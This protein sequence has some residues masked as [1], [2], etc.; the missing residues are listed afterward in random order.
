M[1]MA[2]NKQLEP[3]RSTQRQRVSHFLCGKDWAKP[4]ANGYKATLEGGLRAHLCHWRE[5][6]REERMPPPLL[7]HQ[8]LAAAHRMFGTKVP[9]VSRG[10]GP[11]SQRCRAHTVHV[12]VLKLRNRRNTLASRTRRLQ[13][14]HTP[15]L[16]RAAPSGWGEVVDPCALWSGSWG[17]SKWGTRN[18]RE[19]SLLT[20][21][22]NTR[23]SSLSEQEEPSELR[24]CLEEN[25]PDPRAPQGPEEQH[26]APTSPSPHPP[27]TAG[28]S[29]STPNPED[30]RSSCPQA[31]PPDP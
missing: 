1:A 6:A 9:G 13:M 23:T 20:A 27:P 12:G 5:L 8:R 29:P 30:P 24:A 2:G 4:T 18:S 22:T 15:V 19:G 14:Q 3:E 11:T 21:Q 28:H 31:S 10:A 25:S 26:E 7:S 16:G 17:T